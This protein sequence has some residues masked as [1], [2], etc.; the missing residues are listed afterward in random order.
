MSG[1][2]PPSIRWMRSN[3]TVPFQENAQDTVS[4]T[5]EPGQRE[6]AF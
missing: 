5:A 2:G 3:V 1:A 6:I 4:F